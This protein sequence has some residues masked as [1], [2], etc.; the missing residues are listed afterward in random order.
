[1]SQS[2]IASYALFLGSAAIAAF[3][4]HYLIGLVL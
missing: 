1:M 4:A 2:E 3:A